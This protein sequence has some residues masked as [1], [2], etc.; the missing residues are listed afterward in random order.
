MKR[1]CVDRE[2]VN[3]EF[4]IVRKVYKKSGE[5]AGADELV[6]DIETSKTM[7]EIRAPVEGL[8]NIAVQ[9]GD[10]VAIGGLLFEIGASAEPVS[11]AAEEGRWVVG[12]GAAA[13]NTTERK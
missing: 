8:L 2:N 5:R 4:V 9:A 7:S 3:D 12:G 11:E 1:V 10:E 13:N 6:L